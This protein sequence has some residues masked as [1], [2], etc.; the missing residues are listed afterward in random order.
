MELSLTHAVM[1]VMSHEAEAVVQ[2]N[3]LHQGWK[4][5]DTYWSRNEDGKKYKLK[6]RMSRHSL[7]ISHSAIFLYRDIFST[8]VECFR[9]T[10][11]KKRKKRKQ[12][13]MFSTVYCSHRSCEILLLFV[14]QKK[15]FFIIQDYIIFVQR[16]QCEAC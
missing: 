13:R 11:G 16:L 6:N 2:I 4:L 3:S 7:T 14:P 8:T 12:N 10:A 5:R 9:G 15:C 1:N